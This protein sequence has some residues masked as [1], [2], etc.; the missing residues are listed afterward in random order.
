MSTTRKSPAAFSLIEVTLALG[1]AAFCLLTV[2]GLLPIGLNSTQNASEQTAVSGIATAISADF[3][4]TAGVAL[5]GTTTTSGFQFE[6]PTPGNFPQTPYVQTLYFSQD[7][8]PAGT[9]G[10]SA[11]AG[12]NTTP[13]YRATVTITPDPVLQKAALGAAHSS[14]T[15]L[16]KIWI[17]ITW[18]ALADPSPVA[19]GSYYPSNFAGSFETVTA[20]N[21]YNN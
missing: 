7:G 15:T 2:F 4:G 8:S 3:R 1:I 14:N 13:R 21:Y 19:N 16:Y 9:V 11:A 10:Q 12:S 17:L 18:P 20:V 6:I 5:T